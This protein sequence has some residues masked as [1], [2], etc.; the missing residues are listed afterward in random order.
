M[1]QP[2]D[3]PRLQPEAAVHPDHA[4][5]VAFTPDHPYTAPEKR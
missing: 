4:A 2:I 5:S 1:D 3:Y